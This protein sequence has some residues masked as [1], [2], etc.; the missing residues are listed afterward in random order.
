MTDPAVW[1]FAAAFTLAGT[2]VTWLELVATGLGLGMVACNIRAIHWG[3]PLAAL[4]SLLYLLLFW[5]S[6]LYGQALLQLVF[7][8]VSLWGWQQWLRGRG[9]DGGTLSIGW[10]APRQRAMAALAC[11]ALWPVLAWALLSYTDSAVPWGDAFPTAL[12][13][14]AQML[15]ARKRVENWLLWLVVNVASVALFA[16][17][18]LWPTVVLYAVFAAL[19]VVGWR[20]WKAQVAPPRATGRTP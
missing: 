8:A 11:A 7:I 16:S 2:P 4:S 17:Q 13:L 10:M 3:W 20:A 19:S 18:G 15:L 6:A 9:T 12:S 1:L 14:V 5:H